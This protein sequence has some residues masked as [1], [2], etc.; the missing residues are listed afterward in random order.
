MTADRESIGAVEAEFRVPVRVLEWLPPSLQ[1][2]PAGIHKQTTRKIKRELT[3]STRPSGRVGRRI[4]FGFLEFLPARARSRRYSSG[5]G[6]CLPPY[7]EQ[8]SLLEATTLLSPLAGNRHAIVFCAVSQLPSPSKWCF[9]CYRRRRAQI[10]SGP[11]PLFFLILRGAPL[12]LSNIINFFEVPED[13]RSSLWPCSLCQFACPHPGS[14][15]VAVLARVFLNQTP[16]CCFSHVLI[17]IFSQAAKAK[18]KQMQKDEDT[19]VSLNFNDEVSDGSALAAMPTFQA[20]TSRPQVRHSL[21]IG[22][23]LR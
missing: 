17:V 22:V 4:Y 18:A 8:R 3:T 2:G 6:R 20:F 13:L 11:H 21:P 16:H 19:F 7:P 9:P 23:S 10:D 15:L 1:R 5:A 12:G 14:F